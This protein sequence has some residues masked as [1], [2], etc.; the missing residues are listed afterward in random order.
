[1]RAGEPGWAA[2]GL[3]NKGT[4]GTASLDLYLCISPGDH[5][6]TTTITLL[7]APLLPTSWRVMRSQAA[8]GSM[9]TSSRVSSSTHPELRSLHKPHQTTLRGHVDVA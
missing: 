2:R 5:K 4:L 1:M 3:G 9:A 8:W 7:A 6:A